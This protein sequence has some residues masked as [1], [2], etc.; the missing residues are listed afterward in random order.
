MKEKNICKKKRNKRPRQNVLNIIRSFEFEKKIIKR[1][2]L[3]FNQKKYKIEIIS[4]Y[5]MKRELHAYL[6]RE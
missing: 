2:E 6:M 5:Q 1:S 3:P 4:N